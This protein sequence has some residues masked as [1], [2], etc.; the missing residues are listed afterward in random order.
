MFRTG[1]MMLFVGCVIIPFS[2]A[3]TGPVAFEETNATINGS[4]SGMWVGSGFNSVDYCGEDKSGSQ[5]D[6]NEDSITRLP[7]SIWVV[8]EVALLFVVI[9]R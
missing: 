7:L 9:P 3:I 6:V 4:G 5:A 1:V 8:A 2:N